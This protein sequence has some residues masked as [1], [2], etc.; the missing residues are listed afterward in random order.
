MDSMNM[1]WP[2]PLI[3]DFFGKLETL[4]VSGCTNLSNIV[5][6]NMLRTLRNLKE[7]E[8]EKCSSIEEVFDIQ[9]TNIVE[10]SRDITAAELI[11]L[12]LRNL[13]KVKHVWNMDPQGIITFRK[14]RT[15]EI[16]GCSS[17]K[18]I[19]PTSV[20]KALMQLEKLEIE[21][22]AMV[23][24]IVA[25]EEGIE[26]TTLFKFPQLTTLELQNLP[27][28]KSFYAGNYTSEWRSLKVLHIQKCDK[29]KI[30]GSNKSS[31][32]ETN[33]PAHHASLILRPL[34]SVKKVTTS[35]ACHYILLIYIIY[36]HWIICGWSR[37]SSG[38][39]VCI[40]TAHTCLRILSQIDLS[41]VNCDQT[42]KF[43]WS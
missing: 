19:F 33:G 16:K 8:V 39:R 1:I 34:F 15:I 41:Y 43:W 23:E 40:Q 9:G 14:L 4:T 28:L 7:L 42:K 11:S 31:V 35:L 18:S 2:D 32:E 5:P 21:D 38:P 30:F 22:C 26:T 36:T 17:L 27:E 3:S 20:A 25:K 24:E 29:L 12:T 6:P 37:L 10:E 13:E